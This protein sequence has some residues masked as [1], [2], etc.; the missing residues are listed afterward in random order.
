LI[1]RPR[2]RI[3]QLLA[4]GLTRAFIARQRIDRLNAR[5]LSYLIRVPATI[6][7]VALGAAIVVFSPFVLV[8]N[9]GEFH[10]ACGGILGSALALV[11]SLSIIPAQKAAEGFSTA[12]LRLYA[13][14]NSL[15]AVFSIL[16]AGTLMS[17]YLGLRVSGTQEA[18]GPIVLQLIV[19]GFSFDAIKYFYGRTLEL[20]IPQTAL[21]AVIRECSKLL[22]TVSKRTDRLAKI[23]SL[24]GVSPNDLAP[25]RA[26]VFG[27]SGISSALIFWIAQLEEFAH[28]AISRRDTIAVNAI[29]Q[30]MAEIGNQYAEAR[31]TSL[32]LLPDK[33]FILVSDTDINRVLA[34][35]HE[36]IRATCED[37][38]AHKNEPVVRGCLTTLSEMTLRA[39]TF[40]HESA[41]SGKAA[42]LAYRPAFCVKQCLEIAVREKM[43]D[44][45]FSAIN[46]MKAIIAS[47]RGEVRSAEMLETILDA[48]FSVLVAAYTDPDSVLV[49][50]AATAILLAAKHDIEQRG[51]DDLPVLPTVLRR[52]EQLLPYEIMMDVA[53]KRWM[54]T[55]PAYDL[56]SDYNLAS[57]LQAGID[58]ME[59]PD[60]KRPW[61]NPFHD[62]REISNEMCRHFRALGNLDFQTALLRKWV[63]DVIFECAGVHMRILEKPPAGSEGYLG[64]IEDALKWTLN[65]VAF[66]FPAKTPF[67]DRHAAEAA[68]SLAYI[69]ML[70]LRRGDVT[71]ADECASIISFIAKNCFDAERQGYAFADVVENLEAMALGAELLNLPSPAS[72]YRNLMGKPGAISIE[73]AVEFLNAIVRRIAQM[74]HRVENYR[75]SFRPREPEAMLHELLQGRDLPEEDKHYTW[76]EASWAKA[77]KL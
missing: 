53:K 64:E 5:L 66:L 24:A 55:F 71:L 18:A 36:S 26:I 57:I 51:Y 60:A 38:A 2:Q 37:A 11:L 46:S 39:L 41:T 20:L 13:K 17:L 34:K 35:V 52:L 62:F 31:R 75:D 69:G 27:K 45:I 43:W 54:Q 67:G 73:G 12:I 9:G 40:I 33:E 50:P 47:T 21:A 3:Q 49:K 63:V 56:T 32:I 8:E 22:R 77:G 10:L 4:R 19:L 72:R 28:K 30:G 7:S 74:R 6:I 61:V 70:F 42:P 76:L 58:C 1:A 48:L 65:S 59:P 68:G 15:I 23:Q 14:D 16:A 44:A 25:V 29:V